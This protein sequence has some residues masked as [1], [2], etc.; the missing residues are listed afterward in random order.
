MF[1][2]CLCTENKESIRGIHRLSVLPVDI[3]AVFHLCACVCVFIFNIYIVKSHRSKGRA[4]PEPQAKCPASLDKPAARSSLFV[5]GGFVQL[6]IFTRDMKIN[7]CP[8]C[9]GL[10]GKT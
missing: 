1:L 4:I 2:F 8:A 6:N 10:L 5:E 3:L 9:P 7:S